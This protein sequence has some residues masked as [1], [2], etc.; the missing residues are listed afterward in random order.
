[1]Y[2]ACGLTV[3]MLCLKRLKYN[4]IVGNSLLSGSYTD[5]YKKD[6]K[7]RPVESQDGAR[8]D[9][10]WSGPMQPAKAAIACDQT[11]IAITH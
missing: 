11:T 4:N 1:M 6:V 8:E 5:D 3:I 2:A 7:T 10:D 9:D